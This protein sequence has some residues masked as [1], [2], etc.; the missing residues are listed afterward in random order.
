MKRVF[1]D[2]CNK[3]IKFHNSTW[4]VW[5]NNTEGNIERK[6]NARYDEICEECIKSIHNVIEG[7]RAGA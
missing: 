1:C 6:H 7:R 2:I 3:E 5:M 4:T